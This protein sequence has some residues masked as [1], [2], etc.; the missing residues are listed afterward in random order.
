MDA[1]ELEVMVIL[2]YIES[3]KPSWTT[4][5]PI[6]CKNNRASEMIQQVKAPTAKPEDQSLTPEDTRDLK[7]K[8]IQVAFWLARV[9]GRT[10]S[11]LTFEILDLI[12]PQ[13]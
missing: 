3:S 7:R 1:G 5:D 4:R 6:M 13:V 11:K 8:P 2:G 10:E 9:L 12:D